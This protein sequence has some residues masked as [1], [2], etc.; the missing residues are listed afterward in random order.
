MY[1]LNMD[2]HKKEDIATMDDEVLLNLGLM[3][4]HE[5]L[6]RRLHLNAGGIQPK[7][8]AV[9]KGAAAKKVTHAAAIQISDEEVPFDLLGVEELTAES[10][11]SPAPTFVSSQDAPGAPKKKKGPAKSKQAAANAMFNVDLEAGKVVEE[12]D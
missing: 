9:A 7:K 11:E 6:M 1:G 3:V 4:L 2:A 5:I 8:K 10:Y 12:C